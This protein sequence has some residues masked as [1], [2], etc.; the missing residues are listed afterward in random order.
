MG[1]KDSWG[2]WNGQVHAIFR[3]DTRLEPTDQH[4]ELCSM[5]RGSIDRGRLGEN[6]HIYICG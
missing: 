1:E 6:G 3:M 4:K 5:L 2:V